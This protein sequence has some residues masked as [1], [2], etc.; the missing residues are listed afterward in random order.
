MKRRW[1]SITPPEQWVRPPDVRRYR[2]FWLGSRLKALAFE[3]R[4]S[5]YF[6]FPERCKTFAYVLNAVRLEELDQ[7]P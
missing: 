6:I 4:G 5:T 7:L 1:C 2:L 3:C